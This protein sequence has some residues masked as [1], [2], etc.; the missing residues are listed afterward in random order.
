MHTPVVRAL[1]PLKPKGATMQENRGLG[2][3]T[4]ATVLLMIAGPLNIVY[5]IAAISNSNFFQHNG[6]YVFANLKTWGWITLLLGIL[7]ILAAISLISGHAFGR[8]FAIGVAGL[9]AIGALLE[10]PAYPLWSLAVFAL[11]LWIIRGLAVFEGPPESDGWVDTPQAMEPSQQPI[12][13][14][15]PA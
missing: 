9:A 4:F 13:P 6:H 3:A 10:I 2:R 7:E 11:T 8:W 15:P 12:A 1:H 14:R 5:G